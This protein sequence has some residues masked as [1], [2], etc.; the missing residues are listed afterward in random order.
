MMMEFLDPKKRRQH[1]QKLFVGYGLIAIALTM[2]TII[3]YFAAYGYDVDR[4]TGQVIQN[5]MIIVNAAPEQAR[6]SVNGQDEGTTDKRLSLPAGQY[7]VKLTRDG[8]R[9]WEKSVDLTGSA[10]EQLVYPF[11]FPSTLSTRS[12]QDYTARPSMMT[13]SPDRR[14]LVLQKPGDPTSA[15]QVIDLN[16][17]ENPA[18]T[19]VFPD[20]ILTTGTNHSFSSVEWSTNNDDLL[21]KHVVDGKTEYVVFNHASPQESRNLTTLFEN[22]PFTSARF[23]DRNPDLFYLYNASDKTLY[24]TDSDA[25][26]YTL[27]AKDVLSFKSYQK[28]L[29]VYMSPATDTNKAD[30]HIIYK[31]VDKVVRQVLASPTYTQDVADFDGKLYIAVGASN[32]KAVY[33]MENPLDSFSK[34]SEPPESFRALALEGVT[35]L[36]FSTNARFVAAQAGDKFAVYDAETD[37]QYHYD[38][39]L[40]VTS[41]TVATWMDGHRLSIIPADGKARVF[42]FDGINMQT[43]NAGVADTQVYFNRD[44]DALFTLAPKDKAFSLTRTELRLNP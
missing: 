36:S 18:K 14:W 40:K 25:K 29:I 16:D 27:M 2:L 26:Q 38:I 6:I 13:Q 15:F 19:V 10:I 3:I 37:R 24:S 39:D 7:H 9:D 43:L 31:G 12:I 8:Y 32:D 44:Y 11:M 17:K 42:D 30:V 34:T 41:K 33:I 35:S 20:G 1:R 28:D 23:R 21:L 4:K 22:R 5:G